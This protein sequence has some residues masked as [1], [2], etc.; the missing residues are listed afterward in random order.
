MDSFRLPDWCWILATRTYFLCQWI[1]VDGQLPTFHLMYVWYDCVSFIIF[2]TFWTIKYSVTRHFLNTSDISV[3]DSPLKACDVTLLW[4]A[5]SWIPLI[6]WTVPVLGAPRAS[7]LRSP[8]VRRLWESDKT[9][10]THPTD[11]NRASLLLLGCL[12]N[13]IMTQRQSHNRPPV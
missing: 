4:L 13:H 6:S 1:T 7:L 5:G 8:R 12:Q 3:T 11:H 9:N 10:M 2:I